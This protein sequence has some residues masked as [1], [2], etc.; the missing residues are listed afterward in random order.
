M[1]DDLISRQAAIEE[2]HRYFF[3]G[4]YSNK[5]WNSN[6]VLQAIANVPNVEPKIGQWEHLNDEENIYKCTACGVVWAIEE[7]TPEENEMFFCC[8]CGAK[9]KGE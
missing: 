3:Q 2:L 8:R 7:G 9:M 6:H 4:F 1:N 5:H